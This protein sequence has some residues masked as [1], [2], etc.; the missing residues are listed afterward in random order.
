MK[1]VSFQTLAD[2]YSRSLIGENKV[3]VTFSGTTAYAGPRKDGRGYQVNLPAIRSG[4]LLTPTE[5]MTLS[6]YLDHET[7]H[8]LS[9]NFRALDEPDVQSDETLKALLNIFEDIRIENIRIKRLPGSEKYLN[10]LAEELDQSAGPGNGETMRLIYK[11]A[12]KTYRNIDTKVIL[13]ELS[14]SR[15]DIATEM[16]RLAYCQSTFD[17]LD[18]AR[19]V[20]KLLERNSDERNSKGNP[21][22]SSEKGHGTPN[23][24]T[25]GSEEDQVKDQA[26]QAAQA[27]PDKIKFI[28]EL[29][30][31]INGT[32]TQTPKTDDETHNPY[33]PRDG[34]LA[35][36]PANPSA[37][38]I[39]VPSEE[40][41]EVYSQTRTNASS[42]I[43]LLKKHLSIYLLSRKK[44]AW[45]RGLDDGELDST[46][47]H[48]FPTGSKALFKAPRNRSLVNTA[49]QL[50]IDC[51]SSMS[52]SLTR[53]AAIILAE[54]LA[55]IPNLKL[56]IATFTTGTESYRRNPNEP[57]LG[58]GR[59]DQMI[60]HLHKDF[61][62][63][64]AHCRARLGAIRTRGYTPLGDAYGK[65][66]ERIIS[67]PEPRRIIWLVTDGEPSFCKL[68]YRHSDYVLMQNLHQK[69]KSLKV[70]TLG[71]GIRVSNIKPYVDAFTLITSISDLGTQLLTT[72]RGLVK[73][74]DAK[75]P[76]P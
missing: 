10:R 60:I 68:D 44:R 45:S 29:I 26:D 42:E 30:N 73:T 39:F 51:S 72:L 36:P 66:L 7:E 14:E 8:P 6:G 65:S 58:L 62:E 12:Y 76:K 50:T 38:K 13:G 54:S 47:L 22:E 5:Y 74:Q 40:N 16:R 43:L 20:R 11:E 4:T 46:Q 31:S 15:P 75:E 17:C 61:D 2:K 69:A 19:R 55:A 52:G 3:Q 33:S 41:Q 53:S 24:R 25:D 9:T 64:Y 23:D 59:L 21:K 57:R 67:R 48:Q 28:T 32:Q 27:L 70:E 35:L 63:S 34:D 71:L 1:L 18:L 49:I 56:S 37:D